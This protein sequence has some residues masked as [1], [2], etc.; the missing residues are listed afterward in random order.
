MGERERSEGN[1]DV[2]GDGRTMG[3]ATFFFL[4]TFHDHLQLAGGKTGALTTSKQS[5]GAKF[6]IGKGELKT[7]G[8]GRFAE[9]WNMEPRDPRGRMM[10]WG[11]GMGGSGSFLS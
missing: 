8:L 3:M 7:P 10:G 4:G 9:G 6:N 11:M 1:L 5:Q 2:G